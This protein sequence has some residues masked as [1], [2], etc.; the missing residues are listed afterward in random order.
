MSGWSYKKMGLSSDH[1]K[2]LWNMQEKYVCKKGLKPKDCM[3]NVR[4]HFVATSMNPK[5]TK[6]IQVLIVLSLGCALYSM[7]K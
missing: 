5:E 7:F 6:V 2:L 4:E 1:E 3:Y